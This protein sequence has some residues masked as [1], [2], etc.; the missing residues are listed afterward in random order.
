MFYYFSCPVK[1]R[2]RTE[3]ISEILRSAMGGST[4]SKLMFES[5]IPFSRVNAYL[6]F[7]QENQMLR[8]NQKTQLYSTTE[9]GI[10]F[11]QMHEEMSELFHLKQNFKEETISSLI[12]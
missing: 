1:Y 10:R 5:Y 6:V 7:L 12:S 9:N 4:R 8:Y 11:L 2:C 3:I